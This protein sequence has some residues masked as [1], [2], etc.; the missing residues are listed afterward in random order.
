MNIKILSLNSLKLHHVEPCK[1]YR[2]ELDLIFNYSCI[3]I[4]HPPGVLVDS[5]YIIHYAYEHRL[6]PAHPTRLVERHNNNKKEK[7]GV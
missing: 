4:E 5:T 6:V 1:C 3:A 7:N 2:G